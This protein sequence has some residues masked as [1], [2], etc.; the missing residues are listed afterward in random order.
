MKWN[1]KKQSKLIL[2]GVTHSQTLL[3]P[4]EH[5]INKKDIVSY[6]SFL[7]STAVKF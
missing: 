2:L 4:E 1:K 6:Y 7:N 5:Y 3:F